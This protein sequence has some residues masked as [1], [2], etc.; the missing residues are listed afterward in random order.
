MPKNDRFNFL[1]CLRN[2]SN[3]YNF[4]S[5]VF[6]QTLIGDSITSIKLS[7]VCGG[8]LSKMPMY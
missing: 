6:K 3:N 1:S 2:C 5:L 8:G 4:I 7:T